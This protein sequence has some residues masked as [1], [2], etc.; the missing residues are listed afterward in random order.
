M[1]TDIVHFVERRKD[2]G[3]PWE[4]CG[5]HVE[6]RY[7]DGS[8]GTR[9]EAD[10]DICIGRNYFLFGVLAD[11]RRS[12]PLGPIDWPRGFPDDVSDIV[13]QEL[14]E[15]WKDATFNGSWLTVAEI[16]TYDWEQPIPQSDWVVGSQLAYLRLNDP[17]YSGRD[18]WLQVEDFIA[19]ALE[20][21]LRMGTGPD[22]FRRAVAD[23]IQLLSSLEVVTAG[24]LDERAERVRVRWGTM[25]AQGSTHR[26]VLHDLVT[27]EMGER[28][29]WM[30]VER[31]L[32]RLVPEFLTQTLPA[33]WQ[34]GP[35]QH[36]RLVFFFDE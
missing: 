7:R 11:V 15:G 35:P 16:M 25:K 29:A 26:S 5:R 24:E 17:L 12:L 3:S 10:P 6:V 14:E 1:G 22:T 2:A 28:C 19:S 20:D 32:R 27:E 31:P 9:Y 34:I 8:V 23:G 21:G 33:L 18:R 4:A 13:R 36:V 30:T